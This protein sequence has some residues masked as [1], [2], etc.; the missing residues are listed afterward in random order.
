MNT[1][2]RTVVTSWR[3][4]GQ[5]NE[6]EGT[7]RCHTRNGSAPRGITLIHFIVLF[8]MCYKHLS[9]ST[10]ERWSCIAWSLV[11]KFHLLIRQIVLLCPQRA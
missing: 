4:Q 5:R 7:L 9:V 3:R 1:K 11:S 2:F 10:T 8:Y 6:T